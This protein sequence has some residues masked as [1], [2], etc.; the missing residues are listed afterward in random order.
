MSAFARPSKVEGNR[1]AKPDV[2]H[3]DVRDM[4]SQ[5]R[6]LCACVAGGGGGGGSGVSA[7]Q[8]IN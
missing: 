3:P 6:F 2:K 7:Y 8:I 5:D 1:S 4:E